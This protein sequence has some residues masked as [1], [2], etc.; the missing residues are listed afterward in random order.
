MAAVKEEQA[1][2]RN[3]VVITRR[4]PHHGD[5]PQYRTYEVY[6]RERVGE[7]TEKI[8]PSQLV[9]DDYRLDP[10][11]LLGVLRENYPCYR[12]WLSNSYWIT[13]YNDVTSIFTDDA[14]FETRPR[15][16]Y[17]G[18]NNAGRNLGNELSALVA[19]EKFTDASAEPIA[20]AVIDSMASRGSG[21]LA[22]GFALR[23]SLELLTSMF[24]I[25]ESD[26]SAFTRCYCR[27][28]RGIS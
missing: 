24:A 8:K 3:G 18:L 25:P 6:Q 20:N 28:A 27:M 12:D 26:Q 9:S 2:G 1:V 10:Y 17:Y 16:W 14:N 4:Q 23:Y 5:T 11:P 19:E 7:S 13:R 22:T 15:T 21:D